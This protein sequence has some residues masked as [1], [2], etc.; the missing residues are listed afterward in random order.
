SSNFGGNMLVNFSNTTEPF[1]NKENYQKNLISY[2]ISEQSKKRT[3]SR[4]TPLTNS[5]LTELSP[6][7]EVL[8]AQGLSWQLNESKD[9]EE[10]TTRI[11][12]LKT[13]NV[14]LTFDT[15]PSKSLTEVL[16]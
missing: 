10:F 12:R 4:E 11:K 14:N 15:L 16:K 7:L 1:A 13:L 9:I 2:K 8:S 5:S 6:D 3:F